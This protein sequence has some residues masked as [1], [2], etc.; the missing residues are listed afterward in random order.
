MTTTENGHD[1]LNAFFYRDPF[2]GHDPNPGANGANG[3]TVTPPPQDDDFRPP[4]LLRDFH[5][6]DFAPD[7][8]TWLIEDLLF[9]EQISLVH[10]PHN[11]GKTFMALDLSLTI[12]KGGT[13]QGRQVTPGRV[14]YLASEAGK[15]IDKRIAAWKQEHGYQRGDQLPFSVIAQPVDLCHFEVGDCQRI[16]DAIKAKIGT[17][18]LALLTIETINSVLAGGNE[19]GPED[20]GRLLTMIRRLRD[21]LQCHVML[22]H[23]P[24]KSGPGSRGHYSLPCAVDTELTIKQD[25]E[26]SRVTTV[27]MTK[28]REA[29]KA[30]S[31]AFQLRQVV[32][33]YNSDGKTVTSCVVDAADPPGEKATATAGKGNGKPGRPIGSGDQK[34]AL[35]AL[36][37]ALERGEQA[38]PTIVGKLGIPAHTVVATF[39]LWRRYFKELDRDNGIDKS[40]ADANKRFQNLTYKLYERDIYRKYSGWVWI[41]GG[42]GA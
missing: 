3:A 31:F 36:H 41:V 26:D 7:S 27:T 6:I 30:D 25:D 28:Q 40:E 17:E 24:N 19:N 14:V 35:D 20:M 22:I 9:P 1:D 12:A 29:E 13:W 33:G 34:M 38:P 8:E 39:D 37:M 18:P 23:H 2:A 32:L 42:G 11:S 21:E 16:I 15:G 10:G 5:E 4:L